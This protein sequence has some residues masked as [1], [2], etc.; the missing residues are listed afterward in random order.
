MEAE[1]LRLRADEADTPLRT[2]ILVGCSLSGKKSE[3]RKGKLENGRTKMS[4]G[5]WNGMWRIAMERG[6]HDG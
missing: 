3:T 2:R 1:I 6:N 4:R 5:K